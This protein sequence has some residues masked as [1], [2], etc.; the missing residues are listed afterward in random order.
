VTPRWDTTDVVKDLYQWA[1]V[2]YV[3]FTAGTAEVA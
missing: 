3:S 2:T 1:G